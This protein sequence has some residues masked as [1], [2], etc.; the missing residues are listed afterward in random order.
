VAAAP[1]ICALRATA[2]STAL[3]DVALG[4][5]SPPASRIA[6]TSRIACY[7]NMTS[8]RSHSAHSANVAK[9][10]LRN[11]RPTPHMYGRLQNHYDATHRYGGSNRCTWC[12]SLVSVHPPDGR[13][14]TLLVSVPKAWGCADVWLQCSHLLPLGQLGADVRSQQRVAAPDVGRQGGV[15]RQAQAERTPVLRLVIVR[16]L[17]Q[18]WHNSQFSGKAVGVCQRCI[19]CLCSLNAGMNLLHSRSSQTP[20]TQRIQAG[21]AN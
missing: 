7:E 1:P 16:S 20:M 5:R 4:L 8:V 9:Q 11:P 18:R 2:L 12:A 10:Q 13:V 3:R 6:A 19:A 15:A 17:H 21:N 14:S